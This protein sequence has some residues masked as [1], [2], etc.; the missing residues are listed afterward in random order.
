MNIFVIL[1]YLLTTSLC[2]KIVF[3]CV[4]KPHGVNNI[5]MYTILVEQQFVYFCQVGNFGNIF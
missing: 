4:S 3:T 1:Y 2:Y 5:Y